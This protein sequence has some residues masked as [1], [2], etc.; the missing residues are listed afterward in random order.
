MIFR[1]HSKFRVETKY[2]D[3]C[4]KRGEDRRDRCRRNRHEDRNGDRLGCHKLRSTWR[5]KKQA[6]RKREEEEWKH[7]GK[8]RNRRRK[9]GGK[10]RW[11]EGKGTMERREEELRR[12]RKG[13]GGGRICY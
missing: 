6:R 2:N 10:K 12:Q 4:A 1:Y 5:L 9:K 8:R 11:R 7:R 13:R 3:T